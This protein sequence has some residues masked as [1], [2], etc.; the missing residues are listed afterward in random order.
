MLRLMKEALLTLT[1]VCLLPFSQQGRSRIL[2]NLI[3]RMWPVLFPVARLY[4]RTVLRGTTIVVVIGS[5]G[6]T[7]TFHTVAAALGLSTSR[8]EGWNNR[9]YLALALLR[10]RQSQR[11]AVIEVG[12]KHPGLMQRYRKLL[13]PN[14][15]VITSI[16]TEHHR[17]RGSIVGIREEKAGMVR[18]LPESA[19]IIANGDDPNVLWMASQSNAQLVTYGFQKSNRVRG[20]AYRA[21]GWTASH[22]DVHLGEH[23]LT[24]Q[25]QLVGKHLMYP[26]LAALAVGV[27]A[28]EAPTA[29]ASRLAEL[30]PMAHRLAPMPLRSGDLCLMDDYKSIYETVFAAL[31]TLELL[32][33]NHRVIVMGEVYEPPDSD[34]IAYTTIGERI[35]TIADQ[36]VF[37]GRR[38]HFDF[39]REGAMRK[40]LV[41]ERIHFATSSVHLASDQVNRGLTGD[42]VVLIK[43]FGRQRLQR[44][45]LLLDGRD[46]RC[47]RS[48]CKMLMTRSC[49]DCPLL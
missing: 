41:D 49:V 43:G 46:V 15:V 16:A 5:L 2:P 32:P 8:L 39:I 30:P 11:F 38:E 45:P 31:D 40:G 28:G 35:A 12:A 10:I 23:R 44:I 36:L 25:S 14:M 21:E 6:K 7:S 1:E 47:T 20:D 42:S 27:E 34:E 26:L 19:T 33:A 37:I 17:Q 4:R 29:I 24:L 48:S 22:M 13:D 3:L 18:D 9:G